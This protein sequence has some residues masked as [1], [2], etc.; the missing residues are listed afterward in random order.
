MEEF[1]TRFEAALEVRGYGVLTRAAYV[2]CARK[3][4]RDVG[5]S[6]EAVTVE[7]VERYLLRLRRDRGL[8]PSTCA[9]YAAAW[10]HVFRCLRGDAAM[11]ARVPMIRVPKALPH[12]L[13][14]TEVAK[15]LAAVVEPHHHAIA[16]CCYG[17][18]LR[19][20]EAC[21]LRVHQV[22]GRR[23]VL[24]LKGKGNKERLVPLSASL[25][26]ELRAY[27]RGAR[28][29]GPWLFPGR[30]ATRP[31]TRMAFLMALKRAAKRA[32]VP[33]PVTPHVLR[34]SYA[35]HLIEAGVDLRTLQLRLGHVSVNTTAEYVL[36][37]RSRHREFDSPL[38][39]LG[40]DR[41]RVLG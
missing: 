27:W 15:L 23:A 4:L 31:L 32:N 39:L 6:V 29:A 8:S 22:D 17:A 3:T 11:A 38:D 40:T 12:V 20:T 18:G 10:R 19:V 7:D 25:L 28:P 9:V 41:G 21:Q 1:A 26:S 37:A 16:S 5:M 2:R 35:T 14:G 13:S 34:H 24:R 36:V 33:G 30:P